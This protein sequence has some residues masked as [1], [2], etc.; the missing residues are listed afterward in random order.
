[1]QLDAESACPVLAVFRSADF[2]Q[3]DNAV[4]GIDFPA[5]AIHGSGAAFRTILARLQHV[6]KAGKA[7]LVA[8]YIRFF[9]GV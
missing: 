1:M 9:C 4:Y 6:E 7:F 5:D 2:A 3:C 8:F